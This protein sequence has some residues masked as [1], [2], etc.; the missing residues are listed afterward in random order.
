MELFS[1][2]RRAKTHPAPAPPQAQPPSEQRFQINMQNVLP[3]D[4]TPDIFID[5]MGDVSVINGV[6]RFNCYAV[7]PTASN[8]QN[9]ALVLRLAMAIPTVVATYQGFASL[10]AE[11]EKRGIVTKSDSS[12]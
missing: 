7:Q 3:R 12:S 10:L 8:Q 9:T 2:A 11:F 1:M 6:V 4:N 5:A